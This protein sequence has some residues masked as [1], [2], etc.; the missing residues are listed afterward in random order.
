MPAPTQ[1]ATHPNRL[2]QELLTSSNSGPFQGSAVAGCQAPGPPVREG[3]PA[4]VDELVT[5]L[6]SPHSTAV[7]PDILKTFAGPLSQAC[8]DRLWEAW[9]GDRL[10]SLETLL[11]QKG[12]PA[13]RGSPTHVLSLA[14]LHLER[15]LLEVPPAQIP[16][17]AAL[18]SDPNPDFAATSRKILSSLKNQAAVDALFQFWAITRS[19]ECWNI[20]TAAGYQPHQPAAIQALA[21]LKTGNQPES[22]PCPTGMGPFPGC[23]SQG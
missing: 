20:I 13:G 23:R 18:L 4:A 22:D 3:D 5:G 9:A 17:V 7:H 12:I 11:A 14:L 8:L 10:A 21:A 1:P 16:H 19:A 6:R 2:W 15:E